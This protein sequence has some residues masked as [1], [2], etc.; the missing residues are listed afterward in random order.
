MDPY[1]VL[2]NKTHPVPEDYLSRVELIP[3]CGIEQREFL[4]ERR[5]FAAYEA[6]AAFV[7]EKENIVIGA[8]NGYRSLE[9]QQ[10]IYERFCATYGKD[11]ADAI[12]APVGKSEHHMGIC[13]DLSLYFEGEGFLSNNDHFDRIRPVFEKHIHPH[14]HKFGFILRYPLGKEE[15]T[16]YPYEPWHIR[17]VGSDAARE[18]AREGLTMEE[19]AKNKQAVI[20]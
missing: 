5:T 11:Y 3:V 7:K 1:R 17:Y 13:I 19:W 2:V 10:Q 9:L 18:I 16:G 12:V 8:G 4:L 15:I 6:L 14:L 20:L